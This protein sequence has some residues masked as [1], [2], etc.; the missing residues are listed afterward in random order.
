MIP[1]YLGVKIKGGSKGGNERESYLRCPAVRGMPPRLWGDGYRWPMG[2]SNYFGNIYALGTSGD[3][4]F[5]VT[6]VDRIKYSAF[7]RASNILMYGDNASFEGIKADATWEARVV[8]PMPPQSG[9]R[10]LLINFYPH[11]MVKHAGLC[12][13]SYVDGH[14]GTLK[15]KQ[16]VDNDNDIWAQKS[17]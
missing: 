8:P 3:G 9:T 12:N 13:I 11:Q 4:V 2:P 17:R 7:K 14:C 10:G 6:A 15:E 5:G 16:I 1:M